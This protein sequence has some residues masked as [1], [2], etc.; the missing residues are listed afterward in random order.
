MQVK[1]QYKDAAS[2]FNYTT[3]A[4]PLRIVSWSNYCHPTG[5][6]KPV[7]V[8]QTSPLTAGALQSNGHT[9]ENLQIMILKE[10]DDQQPPL[11]ET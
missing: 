10:T 6:I 2:K 11:A 4:D 1:R 8:I 7:N 9:F 5:M 3:I